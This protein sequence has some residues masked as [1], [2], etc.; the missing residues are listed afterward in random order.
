MVQDSLKHRSRQTRSC[1]N[2][3]VFTSTVFVAEHGFVCALCARCLC[4]C[5]IQTAHI[6]I[7]SVHK[8]QTTTDFHT[9]PLGVGCMY[10]RG[11]GAPTAVF[12]LRKCGCFEWLVGCVN[13]TTFL[14]G[15]ANPHQVPGCRIENKQESNN[16]ATDIFSTTFQNTGRNFFGLYRGTLRHHSKH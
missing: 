8:C 2:H 7:F 6:F 13:D 15:G 9:I 10:Q 14:P 5:C 4:S 11:L 16:E 12:F 3:G 1:M